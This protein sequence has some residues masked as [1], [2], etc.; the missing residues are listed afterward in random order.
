MR[1]RKNTIDLGL[2]L[3]EAIKRVSASYEAVLSLDPLVEDEALMRAHRNHIQLCRAAL[4]HL[5]ALIRLARATYQ[6]D[7]REV[8]EAERL[9]AEARE[10]LAAT[11]LPDEAAHEE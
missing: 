11:P 3:R 4:G 2:D 5:E 1:R 10:A 6:A 8:T 7:Q 9:L